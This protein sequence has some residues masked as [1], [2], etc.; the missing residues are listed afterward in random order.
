[1]HV[2]A[3]GQQ[4]GGVG[5][6]AGAI[7]LAAAAVSA[8]AVAAIIDMDAEQATTLKWAKRRNGKSEPAVVAGDVVTLAAQLDALRVKGTQI[9]FIDLPGRSAPI[10][11]AGLAAADL[12]LIPC[13]P[14]DVD[15]EASLATVQAAKRGGKDYAYLMSIAPPQVDKR[16]ARQV[17]GTLSA[18]GHKVAPVIVVQRVGVPDAIAKGLS[19]I[20]VDPDG[21][22]AAEFKSLLEWISQELDSKL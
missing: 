18:L 10:V 21:D 11:S 12:I 9:V 6:S 17:S 3:L 22:S 4:K 1:M 20:E 8:G 14:L 15:I 16:R 5:K 7:N 13:R 2:V 19:A